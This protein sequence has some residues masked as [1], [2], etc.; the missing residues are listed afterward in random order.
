MFRRFV[1]SQAGGV[2]LPWLERRAERIVSRLPHLEDFHGNV[3]G[4]LS[5]MV[6]R[7]FLCHGC[8]LL[9]VI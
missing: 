3:S 6:E 8:N 9:F 2:A 4:L 5:Q 7:I 1:R